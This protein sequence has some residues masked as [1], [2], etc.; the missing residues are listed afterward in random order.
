M[1]ASLN[2]ASLPNGEAK[3]RMNT[4]DSACQIGAFVGASLLI[5]SAFAPCFSNGKSA[6][7]II[8]ARSKES[9]L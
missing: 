5:A 8:M 9:G 2:F 4:D 7:D 1:I 6:F 3:G